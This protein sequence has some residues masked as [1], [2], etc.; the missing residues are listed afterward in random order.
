V[1]LARRV[2]AKIEV[3]TTYHYTPVGFGSPWVPPVPTVSQHDMEAVATEVLDT[4]VER[5]DAADVVVERTVSEGAAAQ[6]LHDRAVDA[7]L[8]VVGSRGHGGFSGLLLG[9]VSRRCLVDPPT[10]VAIVPS[11]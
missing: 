2:D 10:P 7:D 3:V 5:A 4:A 9:S 6:R 11:H 8:L 1:D